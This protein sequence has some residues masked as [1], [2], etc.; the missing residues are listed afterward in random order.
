MR[1]ANKTP[2]VVIPG[3]QYK[4]ELGNEGCQSVQVSS[5]LARA[6]HGRT[7]LQLDHHDKA[8]VIEVLLIP[9][10]KVGQNVDPCLDK[11]NAV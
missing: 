2:G 11:K 5:N 6:S 8:E 3:R 1:G 10:A 4:R 9:T 7:H